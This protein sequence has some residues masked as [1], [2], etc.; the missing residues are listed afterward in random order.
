[1]L[2]HRFWLGFAEVGRAWRSGTCSWRWK[3][4]IGPLQD[5]GLD[6]LPQCPR[7]GAFGAGEEVD[8]GF[9][10]G[11]HAFPGSVAASMRA[12]T[13]WAQSGKISATRPASSSSTEEKYW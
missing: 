5:V 6:D 13:R 9:D 4:S 7:D 11:P 12:R 3:S 1:M 10:V 8:V 2:G